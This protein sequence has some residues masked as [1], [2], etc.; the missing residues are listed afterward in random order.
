MSATIIKVIPKAGTTYA[1]DPGGAK[2]RGMAGSAG[3]RMFS[4]QRLEWELFCE[5]LLDK[6]D[7]F[8]DSK[9]FNSPHPKCKDLP[10]RRVYES[11]QIFP[12]SSIFFVPYYDAARRA[13]RISD[14]RARAILAKAEVKI[15][16]GDDLP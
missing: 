4:R 15:E 1:V 3:H 10:L 13:L 9:S 11:M 7:A 14:R 5:G 16:N 8:I 2:T 12:E 6:F